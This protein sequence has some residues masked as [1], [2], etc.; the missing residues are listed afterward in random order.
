MR[1]E[2]ETNDI[3]EALKQLEQPKQ[4]LID[5]FGAK[6]I[7]ELPEIPDFRLF[8]SGLISSHRDFDSFYQRL[9]VGEKS[10][11]VSG[12]NPS[13]RLHLGHIGVFDTILF[14]QYKYNVTVYIPLS[15]DES[16][17][18]NKIESQEIGLK[19]SLELVRECLAL[20]LDPKKTKFIIDQIYTNIYNFAIKLSKFINITTIRAVYDY[21]DSD[22]IGLTF[23]PA[24]QSAHI[25]F[26]QLFNI[27]NIL[28]PIGLDEDT[29]IRVCRDI[30]KRAGYEKPA[31]LHFSF[32]PGVDG[33][34]MSKSRGNAIFLY[35]NEKDIR[36][37]VLQAF[38]GGRSTVEE[39]RRL[40]GNPEIDVACIYLKNL[41]YDKEEG[42]KLYED[43]RAGKLLSGEVKEL[44]L[45]E[46][47]ARVRKFKENYNKITSK[48][49]ATSILTNE[50]IDIYAILDKTGVMSSEL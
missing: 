44:F 33:R 3:V 2:K 6:K 48:E 25:L 40:G 16:Y 34:K 27:R 46:I 9:T 28:V 8:R 36:K 7:E 26:P 19:N 10:A 12:L 13:G 14:F 29:H 21:T 5:L 22:N 47:L 4:K 37:K 17:V 32:L 30:A 15:D 35:E 49:M 24:V 39:H 23:Y 42:N 11:I 45:N 50:N 38:S 20:G 18:A 1:K 41:F 31:V 43:Y